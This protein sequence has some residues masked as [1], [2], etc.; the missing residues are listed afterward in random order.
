MLFYPT[1]NVFAPILLCKTLGIMP[2]QAK[3]H[4]KSHR[5][6]G[7]TEGLSNFLALLHFRKTYPFCMPVGPGESQVNLP[8]Y[9]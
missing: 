8:W 6:L 9:G 4:G 5:R 7:L 2:L 3:G 1:L